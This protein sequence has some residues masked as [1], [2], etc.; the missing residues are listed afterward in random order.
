MP[1]KRYAGDR[2]VGPTG[3]PTGFPL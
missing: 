1:V 2:F 3:D